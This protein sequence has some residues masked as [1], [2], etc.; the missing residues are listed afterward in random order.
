MAKTTKKKAVP[1]LS[2]DL[3]QKLHAEKFT[4]KEV[5]LNV[6]GDKVS[7]MVDDKFAEGKIN[8]II[9]EIAE[10]AMS[11]PEEDRL[12]TQDYLYFLILKHFTNISIAT[13]CNSYLDQIRVFNQMVDLGIV[14]QIENMFDE[15]E[16]KQLWETVKEKMKDMTKLMQDEK[17][18]EVFQAELELLQLES[19]VKDSAEFQ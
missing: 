4:Q 7:V 2:T 11:I 6:C 14:G 8:K 10:K 19:Q 13:N 18:A 17:F 15:S 1:Q 5:I 9:V 16:L 12:D 3:I